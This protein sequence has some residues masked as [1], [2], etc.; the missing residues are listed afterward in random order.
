MW[1]VKVA[2]SRPYTFIVLALLML[3]LGP[4]IIARTPTDIFPSTDSGQFLLHV[5]AKSG[6][7]IEETARLVD[8][9]EDSIR[10][11][12]P[13]EEL[14]TIL[15][16]IGLPSRAHTAIRPD[17]HSVATAQRTEA[18]PRGLGRLAFVCLVAAAVGLGVLVYTGIHRRVV[19][20]ANR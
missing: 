7:R 3:I 16:N 11:A 1:I 14:G 15:D 10:R 20:A 6:T 8:L 13:P 12:I 17:V 18:P 9:V 5:R 4:V 2:L 19:A